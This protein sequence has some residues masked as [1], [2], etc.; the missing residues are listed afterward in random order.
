[1]PVAEVG[2]L[3]P[4]TVVSTSKSRG[5]L[6]GSDVTRRTIV[7]NERG[8]YIPIGF[9]ENGDGRNKYYTKTDTK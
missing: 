4:G 1:M 7:G 2:L 9:S 5:F 3:E 8:G 6:K